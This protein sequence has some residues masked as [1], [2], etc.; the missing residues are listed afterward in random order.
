MSL[1]RQTM[2]STAQPNIVHSSSPNQ[3][4]S[5][6][7][8]GSNPEK[9]NAHRTEL[10]FT[11]S[12][13]TTLKVWHVHVG[14]KEMSRPSTPFSYVPIESDP[15][16][17]IHLSQRSEELCVLSPVPKGNSPVAPDDS[18]DSPLGLKTEDMFAV[19]PDGYDI[20]VVTPRAGAPE[21]PEPI[22]RAGDDSDVNLRPWRNVDYLS[23][24]WHEEDIWS[25]WKHITS[26]R[27]EYPDS[28]RLENAAWR[29]WTKWMN[30]LK[31]LPPER[32]NWLKDCDV[33]W[34][35]GPLQPDGDSIYC[36]QTESS[37]FSFAKPSSLANINKKPILKKRSVSDI[38]L[39]G[40][41]S[42][43]LMLRQ[44]AAVVQGQEGEYWR[45]KKSPLDRAATADHVRFPFSSRQRGRDC[46]VLRTS[47]SSEN[48][49][50]SAERKQIHFNEKVEQCIAVETG[51]V[52]N[53][54]NT[55][56]LGYND[57]DDGVMMKLVRSRKPAP[58]I[59]KKSKKEKDSSS[60]DGKAITMLPSTTLKHQED[61][62]EP[63]ETARKHDADIFCNPIV[64]QS[65]SQ[66]ALHPSDILTRFSERFEDF[67]L[68]RRAS[69]TS[70]TAEQGDM[71]RTPAGMFMPDEEE[72]PWSEDG[73]FGR[74]IDT[75]NAVR[76]I[77]YIIWHVG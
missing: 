39:Q 70:L 15:N 56:H 76:D 5:D 18:L 77:A 57:S 8:D 19:S 64:P 47:G 30:N 33:T 35:Y 59:R 46:R 29:A 73:I 74:I 48:S 28:A 34:L 71:C 60:S 32:L 63:S 24:H 41:S 52:D 67:G 44:G 3:P 12:S 36:T 11:Y 14:P 66:E 1:Q 9:L 53:E 26:R 10:L 23:H 54:V 4:C 43:S 55:D 31:T 72:Q 17:A 37:N 68:H 65:S 13:L 20:T 58:V 27:G 42:S 51:G 16:E 61:M 7:G 38:M 40:P 49:S 22:H 69:A 2:S 6:F 25:S 50:P 21:L 45:S 62:L 75:V